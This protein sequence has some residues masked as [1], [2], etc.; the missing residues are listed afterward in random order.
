MRRFISDFRYYM[1][2]FRAMPLLMRVRAAWRCAEA[3]L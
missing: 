3:T 2:T 1:R